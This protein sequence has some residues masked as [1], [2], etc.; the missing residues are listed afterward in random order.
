MKTHFNNTTDIYRLDGKRAIVTGASKGIGRAI[1]LRLAKQGAD[2]ILIARNAANLDSLKKEINNIGQRAESF[3]V[4]VSDSGQVS[5]FFRKN[6]N[7]FG[8]VDIFINNA[9]YTIYKSFTE[10][11]LEDF[12]GLFATN[13]KGAVSFM[14][15]AANY[16]KRQGQGG[17]IVIVT[18]VNALS[19][20]PS[21]AMY[22]ATKSMLES[23]MKSAAAELAEYGIRVNSVVPGAIMTDMNPHFTEEYVK[24]Y[25]KEI[26]AGRVGESEDIADV[27]AFLCSE[28][29]RYIYGSSIVVDGGVLL[30]PL[31]KSSNIK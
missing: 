1:A 22:S 17:C 10:T 18:S 21:Q 8:G 3:V 24:E 14:Q 2:V 13:V 23:L 25:Q 27:T 9:A 12:D 11:T 28:A 20:L 19:A 5:E 26:P 15:G 31:K 7:V 6:A 29:A 30:R 16:M 4:D